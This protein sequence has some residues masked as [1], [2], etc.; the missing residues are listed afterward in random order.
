M[1]EPLHDKN[2][3]LYADPNLAEGVDYARRRR[4]H[5]RYDD[6][7]TRTTELAKTVILAPHGGGIER[8]HLRV[9]PG[10]GRLPP[11]QPA[12]HATGRGHL[13]PLDVRGGARR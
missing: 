6:S 10:R 11:G 3:K 9:L 8:W 7:L 5:E 12:H 2:A 13:R 4:R 1:Q